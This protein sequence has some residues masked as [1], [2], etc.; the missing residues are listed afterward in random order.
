M[1]DLAERSRAFPRLRSFV[2]LREVAP[3]VTPRWTISH[4]R[5]GVTVGERTRANSM[6]DRPAV[7]DRHWMISQPISR[8]SSYRWMS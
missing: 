8:N 2:S 5:R 4:C 6:N 1:S 3:T 7:L